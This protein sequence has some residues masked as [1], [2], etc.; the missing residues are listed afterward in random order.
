M[1]PTDQRSPSKAPFFGWAIVGFTLVMQFLTMG[2]GYYTYGVLLVPLTEALGADRFLVS[3]GLSL[4]TLV[5][6]LL[7]PAV[8]KAVAERSVR[9]LMLGGAGVLSAG[10]A[11]LSQASQLWHLYIA[12]GVVVATGIA[13]TGPLPNN[14]LLANWFVERRG[15]ALGISQFGV[16]IS[17]TVMVPVTSWIV[18][19]WDW[20]MAAIVFAA[21]PLVIMLPLIWKLA[22]KRPEDMGLFADGALR[23]PVGLDSGGGDW[24]LSRALKD[25]QVR[26]LT[27]VVG[28]T[29]M[30]IGSVVLAM[31]SYATDVGLTV[32]QASTIVA[33]I[34]LAGAL[35]K[36]LFGVLSDQF[37]K[38]GV[39]TASLACQ[40][41][42]V[43]GI[44]AADG[45]W[46]LAVSGC[47]FGL[48]YGG[49]MPLWSVLIATLFGHQAFARVMG[50]MGPLTVP[51]TL[52]GLPF[53]TFVFELTG[54]Y[55]PAF[56]I[57][58]TA[59]FVSLAAVW[60][61]RLPESEPQHA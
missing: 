46:G 36:P 53:T 45:F 57:M 52:A 13:L 26:L 42:G 21:A 4:Q 58:L 12:Y 33:A 39:V 54:S 3:L 17:G 1:S 5:M 29:F 47:L 30:A 34:T 51:F 2:T 31:H 55:V 40:I 19:T 16:T 60:L 25:R 15:T 24:N 8:G 32:L 7:G 6:A 50:L 14:A 41:V 49:V 10:F 23:S 56:A 20:R 27:L 35:A 38:R 61:L 11:L 18:V 37:D 9:A 48:G 22:V 59:F 28:P 44:I 43:I